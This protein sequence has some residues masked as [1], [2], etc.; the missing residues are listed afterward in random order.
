MIDLRPFVPDDTERCLDLYSAVFL[1]Q[2]GTKPHRKRARAYLEDIVTFP[3]FTGFV[4]SD[5]DRILG[6]VFGHRRRWWQGDE[7]AIQEFCLAGEVSAS[8]L[9]GEL[10]QVLE[11]DLIARGYAAIT[12]VVSVD[13]GAYRLY[14]N[15]DYQDRESVRFLSKVLP[16]R[17]RDEA[18]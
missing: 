14:L 13:S 15:R 18:P 4:A 5:G 1:Q 3:D 16:R 6:F 12:N 17:R 9:G 10:L 2:F 8:E 11:E 7:F